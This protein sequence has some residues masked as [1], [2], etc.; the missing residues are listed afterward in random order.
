MKNQTT[1]GCG[2]STA[3]HHSQY[4]KVAEETSSHTIPDTSIFQEET[5]VM[6][7]ALGEALR[8]DQR[9]VFKLKQSWRAVRRNPISTALE[10]MIR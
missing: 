8:L 9:D 1:M 2:S 3:V 6:F 10:M 5:V 7:N 4:S